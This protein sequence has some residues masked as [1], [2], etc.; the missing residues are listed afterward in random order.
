MDFG[1]THR[2]NGAERDPIDG[3]RS[4]TA[5]L[6]ADYVFVT[7]GSEATI[8]QSFRMIGPSG[9]SVLVGIPAIGAK[10]G[11]NPVKLISV[12]QRILGSKMGDSP[13][14]RDIP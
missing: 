14:E 4:V 10:A 11:F 3:V 7:V 13:I 5:G 9:A 2:V 8:N 6:G 12:S 1:A